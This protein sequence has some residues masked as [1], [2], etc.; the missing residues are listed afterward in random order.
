MQVKE[1]M[2]EIPSAAQAFMKMCICIGQV[3]KS[4]FNFR[5]GWNH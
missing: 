4:G 1:H 3:N 5:I 2:E